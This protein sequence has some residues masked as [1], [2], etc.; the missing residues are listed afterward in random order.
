MSISQVIAGLFY[1]VIPRLGN[2]TWEHGE[3]VWQVIHSDS[4]EAIPNEEFHLVVT[5][6]PYNVNKAYD[7]HD[8]ALPLDEWVTLITDV[9]TAA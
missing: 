4:R 3:M 2:P 7:G 9:L 8:D 5:S 6:P 1:W